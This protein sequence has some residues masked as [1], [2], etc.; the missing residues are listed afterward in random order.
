MQKRDQDNWDFAEKLR[1]GD[2]KYDGQWIMVKNSKVVAHGNDP[3]IFTK[4]QDK[5]PNDV[6]LLVKIPNEDDLKPRI[7]YS[8]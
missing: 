7:L 4:C 3:E 6:M 2:T 1:V 8:N 5:Y